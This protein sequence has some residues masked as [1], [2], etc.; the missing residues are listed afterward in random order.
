MKN[1]IERIRTVWRKIPRAIR[2]AWI[3]AWVTFVGATLSIITG[4]LPVL[5]DSISSKN[6]RPFFDSLNLGWTAALSA[7]LGFVSGLVNGIWR[8]LVPIDKAYQTPPGEVQMSP[9]D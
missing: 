5:A 1:I 6:F 9:E 8:A 4:L 7:A 2:S 3:T